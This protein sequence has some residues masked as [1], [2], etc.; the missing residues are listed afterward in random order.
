[1][2]LSD[3]STSQFLVNLEI[4]KPEEVATRYNVLLER[5]IKIREIEFETLIDMIHQFVIPSALEYKKLLAKLIM[6]QKEIG[7]A[8]HFEMDSFKKVSQQ[9]DEIHEKSQMLLKELESDHDDHQKYAEKIAN[10]LM[11]ISTTMANI[12]NV[13]ED[14][15]PNHFYRLPKYYDMLFLR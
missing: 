3:L 8:S 6:N 10:E 11:P 1:M 4:F 15:I 9:I 5:Y 7:V 12:C 13:L 14:L 2:V